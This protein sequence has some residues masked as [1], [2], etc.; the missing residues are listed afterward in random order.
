MPPGSGVA[1]EHRGLN[2]DSRGHGNVMK[3]YCFPATLPYYNPTGHMISA[4]GD[5]PGFCGVVV[6][7]ISG[8]GTVNSAGRQNV[9]FTSSSDYTDTYSFT[10]SV[11]GSDAG[12]AIVGTPH[13][14]Q[15]S[16]RCKKN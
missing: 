13:V 10:H 9:R 11:L 1:N 16:V 8:A 12:V 3:D 7:T 4:G 5:R 15:K 14:T 2:D 6:H